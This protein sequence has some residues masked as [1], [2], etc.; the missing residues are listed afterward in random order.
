[1]LLFTLVHSFYKLFNVVQRETSKVLLM[2]VLKL[3][4]HNIC[5]LLREVIQQKRL[6]ICIEILRVRD[7]RNWVW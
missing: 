4:Y 7:F 1:M 3:L 2:G 5:F 6:Q